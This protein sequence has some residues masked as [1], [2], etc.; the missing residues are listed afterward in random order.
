[1]RTSSPARRANGTRQPTRDL[2]DLATVV[3]GAGAAAAPGVAAHGIGTQEAPN[4]A[5]AALVVPAVLG[6]VRAVRRRRRR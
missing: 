3:A 2:P 1:M 5:I 4:P 6:D